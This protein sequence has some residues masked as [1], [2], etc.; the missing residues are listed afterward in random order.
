MALYN[1]IQPLDF[2]M[3]EGH[4]LSAALQVLR[5]PARWYDLFGGLVATQSGEPRTPPIRSLVDALRL[6]APD[7]VFAEPDGWRAKQSPWL[8]A[9]E[10]INEDV[11]LLVTKAWVREAFNGNHRTTR[12]NDLDEVAGQ[13]VA[14][15]LEWGAE[16]VDFSECPVLPNETADPSSTYF[17]ALPDL[18]CTL[19]SRAGVVVPVGSEQVRLRRAYGNTGPELVSWPPLSYATKSGDWYW[20]YV[21]TPTV[22]TFPAQPKPV[23][24]CT[25]HVRRWVTRSLV[26]PSGFNRLPH[27]TN[28]SAYV[29]TEDPWLTGLP[30][31]RSLASAR[32]RRASTRIDGKRDWVPSWQAPLEPILARLQ[33][34]PGLPLAG[35]VVKDPEAFINR[36]GAA[37]AIVYRNALGIQHAVG[38]GVPPGDRRALFEALAG[39]LGSHGLVPSD[40]LPRART[41]SGHASA[42]MKPFAK[43]PAETRH[44]SLV[45][46]SGGRLRFEILAPSARIERLLREEVKAALDLIPEEGAARGIEIYRAAG[47]TVEVVSGPLG[48]LGDVL[49][50]DEHVPIS[51][52][53]DRMQ[54]MKR[55]AEEVKEALGPAKDRVLAL[56]ELSNQRGD[57]S[58]PKDAIRWGLA[59]TGRL[60][61][62][63]T[64]AVIEDGHEEVEGSAKQRAR[65]AV[66]DL[67]RQGGYLPGTVLDQLPD[68]AAIP[69]DVQLL[70]LWV[71]ML[72]RRRSDKQLLPVI[73]SVSAPHGVRATFPGA[74]GWLPYPEAL[75]EVA[76]RQHE[77]GIP[78]ARFAAFVEKTLHECSRLSPVLLICHGQNAR[79]HWPWLTN[80]GL[81][82]DKIIWAEGGTGAPPAGLRVARLRDGDQEETPQ[83]VA[84]HDG[85]QGIPSGLFR[86]RDERT[87]FSLQKKSLGMKTGG[88]TSKADRPRQTVSMPTLEEIWLAV[89]EEGDT[90]E[91]W[92][93]LVHRLREMAS[94]FDEALKYPLPLHLATGLAE[95]VAVRLDRA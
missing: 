89:L 1:Q 17:K 56:V 50:D 29:L 21:I 2:Q 81:V 41:R 65:S 7:L 74:S 40:G 83:W 33:V 20:S 37:A 26:R 72:D 30:A 58:D 80:K 49:T 9:H 35:E 66:R 38:A 16:E 44:Q 71:V 15:D 87:F 60:S 64:P 4:R 27:D 67:L 59:E 43:V 54:A 55:R 53:Q 14:A 93:L 63:I 28:T 10:R 12:P 48:P 90:P 61:Q 23:L 95:Y 24:R 51:R 47:L 36:R 82:Q 39:V 88:N 5:M 34:T 11:L 46:V 75:V 31:P 91:E 92:A 73:V 84:E 76:R 3:H 8:L 42:L 32:L 70:G 94:H 78:R 19:V 45:A 62:F 52:Q 79:Q 6:L 68:E 13:L 77:L 86:G 22:Q 69:R 57:P 25:V 18:V 85:R